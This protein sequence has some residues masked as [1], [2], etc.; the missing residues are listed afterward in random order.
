[1]LASTTPM[2][3]SDSSSC[4]GADGHATYDALFCQP[5]ATATLRSG[6]GEPLRIAAAST[7]LWLPRTGASPRPSGPLR[8]GD[9]TALLQQTPESLM[10]DAP[11]PDHPTTA[12]TG[13][14]PR[15][16][17]R[18]QP[19]GLRCK[20]DRAENPPLTPAAPATSA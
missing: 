17:C 20:P 7:R 11:P 12:W 14:V 5:G 16:A 9:A 18:W 15:P 10:L 19:G 4:F 3:R 13:C 1:M 8:T 6:R 2:A